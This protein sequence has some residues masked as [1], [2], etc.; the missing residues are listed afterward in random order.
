MIKK[1]VGLFFTFVVMQSSI[2]SKRGI[3]EYKLE[4]LVDTP[5]DYPC[6][7]HLDLKLVSGYRPQEKPF[8][9]LTKGRNK[10][11][12]LGPIKLNVDNRMTKAS[13][14]AAMKEERRRNVFGD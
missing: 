1:K 3:K 10:Q 8:N 14:V 11:C 7:R 12:R 6:T 9:P 4:Q 2:D 13:E 5:T